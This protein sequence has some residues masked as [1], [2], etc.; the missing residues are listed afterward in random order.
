MR[1]IFI[2][3]TSSLLASLKEIVRKPGSFFFWSLDNLTERVHRVKVELL[4]SPWS[5]HIGR[6]TT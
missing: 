4:L 5:E 3:V 6:N 1:K 2:H